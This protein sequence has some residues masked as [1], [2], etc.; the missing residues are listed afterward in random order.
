MR[1]VQREQAAALRWINGAYDVL[2]EMQPG[3]DRRAAPA[4]WGRE[5]MQSST[6]SDL[7]GIKA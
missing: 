1:S 7:F 3:L 6:I 4:G 2:L 5:S